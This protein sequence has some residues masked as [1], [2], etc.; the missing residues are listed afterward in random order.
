MDFLSEYYLWFLVG[1]IILVM[2]LIGYIAD[3]TDF[4][5]KEVTPKQKKVKNDNMTPSVETNQEI[6][7]V[8]NE[9]PIN[10]ENNITI[11][12]PVV[13]DIPTSNVEP[14]E[15]YNNI[16]DIDPFVM[17]SDNVISEQPIVQEFNEQP[18]VEEVNN[19]MIT[20]EVGEQ[21]FVQGFNEMPA[22]KSSDDVDIEI[23]E[24]TDDSTFALS[25]DLSSFAA[26]EMINSIGSADL[27]NH[28]VSE[29][30]SEDIPVEPVI[31]AEQTVE[32]VSP[33]EDTEDDI[34]KF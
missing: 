25:D 32:E 1:G 27:V 30:I 5:R 16:N 17:P 3:K 18:F 34:W 21:P 14:A 8:V 28:T 15:T 6:N 31:N 4:G 7:S 9:Q 20:Q 24:V 13:Q 19:Q 2:A 23:K 29:V 11:E 12:D 10:E 22:I 26:A 33:I